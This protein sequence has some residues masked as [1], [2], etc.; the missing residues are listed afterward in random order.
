MKPNLLAALAVL[1]LCTPVRAERLTPAPTS[2]ESAAG[3]HLLESNNGAGARGCLT[4]RQAYE[5]FHRTE[6]AL[7]WNPDNPVD[8]YVGR[9]TVGLVEGLI[10]D[11]YGELSRTWNAAFN[12]TDFAAIGEPCRA[13]KT[14][15]G[16]AACLEEKTHGYFAAH[17]GLHAFAGGDCKL[18]SATL[19]AVSAHFPAVTRQAAITSSPHH[20]VNRL[21]IRDAAG[22]EHA[23]LVDSLNNLVIQLSDDK[24]ACPAEGALAAAPASAGAAYETGALARQ[25]AAAA[26]V[27]RAESVSPMP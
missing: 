23:F 11:G 19:V 24:G 12:G 10:N 14:P 4:E 9:N 17:P 15:R 6:P 22:H 2:Q 1:V 8:W 5:A 13:Q 20:A 16:L 7:A 26:R 25:K 3:R 27:A 21:S 18:Y